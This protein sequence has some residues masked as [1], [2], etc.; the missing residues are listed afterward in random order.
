MAH[1]FPNMVE[2]RAEPKEQIIIVIPRPSV[3]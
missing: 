1:Y 2:K 3:G